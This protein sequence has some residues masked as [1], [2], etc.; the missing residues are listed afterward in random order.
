MG[1]TFKFLTQSFLFTWR[2]KQCWYPI[3][4]GKESKNHPFVWWETDLQPK[5]IQIFLHGVAND[6]N[7]EM[8]FN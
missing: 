6:W 5:H 2:N 4:H 1:V 3:G 7:N 8:I